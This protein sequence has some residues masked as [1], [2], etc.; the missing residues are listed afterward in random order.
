MTRKIM[1]DKKQ[2]ELKRDIDIIESLIE[3]LNKTYDVTLELKNKGE[4]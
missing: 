1:T 2:L 3:N 4:Y